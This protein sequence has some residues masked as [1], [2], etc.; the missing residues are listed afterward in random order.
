MSKF[1]TDRQAHRSVQALDLQ[2]RQIL[3][4][5]QVRSH[6]YSG[7]DQAERDLECN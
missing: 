4:P 3:S 7:H 1:P 2:K 5:G 6:R